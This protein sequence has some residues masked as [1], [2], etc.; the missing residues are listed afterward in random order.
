MKGYDY[1]SPGRYVVTICTNERRLLFGEIDNS[2]IRPNVYGGIALA[3]WN[4]LPAHFPHLL[5]D[6][7]VL[8]PNHIHGILC[9]MD[10]YHSFVGAQ[11]AAPLQGNDSKK[12]EQGIAK[13]LQAGSLP[14]LVRSYKSAV[15]KQINEFRNTP[16]K[17]VWQRNYF[18]RIIRS[19]NE[20]LT[21]RKYIKE[22]PLNWDKDKY[23]PVFEK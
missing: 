23:H 22:N 13:S 18:E 10:E 4:M 17:K 16:G 1:A 19:D 6:C 14:V 8:M 20:L 7:F 11:H 3:C 9:I 5:L 2:C 12:S 15:T 21:F